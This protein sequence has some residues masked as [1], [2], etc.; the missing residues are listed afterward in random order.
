MMVKLETHDSVEE[1]GREEERSTVK[2]L[3]WL[4]KLSGV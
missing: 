1:R 3:S 4:V 2:Q